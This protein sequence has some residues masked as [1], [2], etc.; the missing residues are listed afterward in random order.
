MEVALAQAE[1]RDEEALQLIDLAVQTQPAF[2]AQLVPP[3]HELAKRRGDAAAEQQRLSQWF[4]AAPSEALA[5]VIS[6]HLAKHADAAAAQQF[7]RD[8]FAKLPGLA[9]AAGLTQSLA[10]ESPDMAA[11]AGVLRAEAAR[12]QQY[13]CANCGFKARQF[14]W[15]CPGCKRWETLPYS[16]SAKAG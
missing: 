3:L 11:L 4:A 1:G 6:Q 16:A 10:P 8:A 9:S 7:S 5:G 13:I 14:Y 2:A 12:Q 15:Q